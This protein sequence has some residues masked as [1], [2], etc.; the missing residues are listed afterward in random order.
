M[1]IFIA[2]DHG[3]FYLK[4][5]LKSFLEN[6]KYNVVD[7][8]N[9]NFEKTDDY[10]DFVFPLAQ[11][12][13]KSRGGLG[14]VLGRSGI[15]ESI[16][17]NKVKGVRA[18]LC[19]NKKLA[20]KAREHNHANVLSLGADYINPTTAKDIVLEFITTHVSQAGRHKRRVKK[21]KKH[22]T[23]YFRKT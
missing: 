14:I 13:A 10:P 1:K 4:E 23:A 21:I 8:G 20:Q 18:A 5:E 9:K 15:G 3:G 22:E 16:A 6:K 11:N 7:I 17:A 2:S 19:L 12:V